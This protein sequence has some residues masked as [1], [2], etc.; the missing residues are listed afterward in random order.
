MH[1]YSTAQPLTVLVD[2]GGKNSP[3]SPE[4]AYFWD[5]IL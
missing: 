2:F 3:L 5:A 1:D 4:N